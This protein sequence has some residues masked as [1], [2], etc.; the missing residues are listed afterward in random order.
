MP[1]LECRN[2]TKAFGGLTALN[3][4]SFAVEKGEILGLIGPNGAGKT[5]LFN[6]MTGVY[7]PDTGT[8]KFNGHEIVG[9]K[10]HEITRMG[11]ARTFQSVRTFQDQTVYEDIL[12]GATF[13]RRHSSG[14]TASERT[15]KIISLMNLNA[16]HNHT[17]KQL[18]IQDRKY[19]E[20]GRALASEPTMLL[21]D[22]PM[23]G[24]TH[25]EIRN[26][27]DV[28]QRINK[29]GVSV[30]LVE[31]VMRAVM[32]ISTRMIVLHHGEK[33]AEGAPRDIA[34]DR[35]VVEVYLGEKY[36]AA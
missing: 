1:I 15:R 19:V 23:A 3:G 11:I 33:I 20:I 22:E 5:T 24:L 17:T 28:I 16:K 18:T 29:E 26:L 6:V 2:V 35:R 8:I 12:V 13:G 36:A 34:K 21:L 30:L 4:V 25:G 31:H 9:R 14:T 7:R 10:P 27:A 32:N